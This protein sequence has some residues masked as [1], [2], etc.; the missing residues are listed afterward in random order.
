MANKG[1]KDT[2][3]KKGLKQH[4]LSSK[5]KKEDEKILESS[6]FISN[7]GSEESVNRTISG[8]MK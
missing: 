6:S 8:R 3:Q 1:T 2:K 5:S 7:L 4:K